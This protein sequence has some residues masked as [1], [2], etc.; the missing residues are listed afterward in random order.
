MTPGLSGA[1]GALAPGKLAALRRML[2]FRSLAVIGGGAWCA[3]VIRQ[4]RKLG[5]SGP[6]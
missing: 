5:F 2:R 3:E 1:A 4:V 6:V